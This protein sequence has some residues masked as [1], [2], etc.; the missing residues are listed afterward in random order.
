MTGNVV[1]QLIIKNKDT[2]I[3]QT[4]ISERIKKTEDPNLELKSYTTTTC[5]KYIGIFLY[6]CAKGWIQK[7]NSLVLTTP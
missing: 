3:D 6:W 1:S 7:K 2:I 4:P 5:L